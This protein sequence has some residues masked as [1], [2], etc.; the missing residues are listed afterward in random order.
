MADLDIAYLRAL[1]SGHDAS[2][3][4]SEKQ[5]LRDVTGKD[6]SALSIQ[7]LASLT[8]DCALSL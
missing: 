4:A 7:H 8:L 2:A 5:A 3:I 1:E 6:L